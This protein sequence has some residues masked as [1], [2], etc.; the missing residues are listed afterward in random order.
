[1]GDKTSGGIELPNEMEAANTEIKSL[2]LQ[3]STAIA[4]AKKAERDR[5]AARKKWAEREE[6]SRRPARY[7]FDQ[8][9][10]PT[11]VWIGGREF[12]AF[13]IDGRAVIRRV[14]KDPRYS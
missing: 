5:D 3:L 1:M 4:R 12:G 2:R 10:N 11:R 13:L 9:P 8:E 6:M 14:E 7:S